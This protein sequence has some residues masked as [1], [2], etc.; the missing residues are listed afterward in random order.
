MSQHFLFDTNDFLEILS[1]PKYHLLSKLLN[2]IDMVDDTTPLEIERKFLLKEIPNGLEH[3]NH[4][5]IEQFYL[6]C[7]DPQIRIRKQDTCYFLTMK[8]GKGVSRIEKEK[9]ITLEEY[10]KLLPLAE[11]T[12]SKLR[13]RIPLDSRLIAE[14]DCYPDGKKVVEVE[15]SSLE[16]ATGFVPPAWF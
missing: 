8:K 6:F 2:D 7:G 10:K 5:C 16:D 4:S 3:F 15:F 11:K 13:Y 12:I 1:T 14:V 9:E